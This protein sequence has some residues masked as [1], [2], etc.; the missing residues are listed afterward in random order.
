[1]NS[2]AMLLLTMSILF[3]SSI[4]FAEQCLSPQK[5]TEQMYKK[6]FTGRNNEV[7]P[8]ASTNIQNLEKHLTKS[9]AKKLIATIPA[10]HKHK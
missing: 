10:K 9:L 7:K 1:M 3:S 2:F 8:L 5:L 4:S 6:Y